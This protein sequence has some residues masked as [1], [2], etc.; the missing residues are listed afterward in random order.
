[1]SEKVEG[2]KQDC[3]A[4]KT[5]LICVEI[6]EEW[7]GKVTKKLQWQN[8]LDHKPHF[9][10][11]SKGKYNCVKPEETT[12]E[13]KSDD[14]LKQKQEGIQTHKAKEKKSRPEIIDVDFVE[15]EMAKIIAIRGIVY[16]ALGTNPNGQE[17][18]LCI[19][20]IYDKMNVEQ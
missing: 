14:Y 15:K 6:E 20:L 4:C 12:T 17:V 18:G 10:Y 16:D 2:A 13:K 1:M 7:Q 5:K 3:G 9:R 11:V 8:E 19:K